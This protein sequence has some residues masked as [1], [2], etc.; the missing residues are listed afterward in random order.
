MGTS[1][2]KSAERALDVLSFL[3]S[4]PAPVL[5]SSI[6]RA[7][8]LPKSST[9]HLLNVM[10]DRG[11]VSYAPEGRLW[12]IGTRAR[13]VGSGLSK[14]AALE[15][16][17]RPLIRD[18]AGRVG[19]TVL[20]CVPHGDEVVVVARADGAGQTL[21]WLPVAGDRLPAHLSA[22]GRAI[23]MQESAFSLR[24]SFPSGRELPRVTR[25]GPRHQADLVRLLESHRATG[26][27][28]DAS[29]WHRS[30]AGVAAPVLDHL[31]YVIATVGVSYWTPTRDAAA[32]KALAADIREVAD[33][34]SA[35]LGFGEGGRAEPRSEAE[36][37]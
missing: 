20:V 5:A 22:Y 11:F 31:G 6:S 7:I 15:R 25:N 16:L 23:W 24:R 32:V 36:A 14:R 37:V 18:L 26:Y 19:D 9:Y 8:G 17:S 28:T 12:G 35:R 30:A 21:P 34:L 33:R 10:K 13:D 2:V 27:A 1:T 4:Q 3:S 29:E